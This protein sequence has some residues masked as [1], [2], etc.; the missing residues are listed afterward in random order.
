[1][2]LNMWQK[3]IFPLVVVLTI[4]VVVLTSVRLLITPAFPQIEYRM[5]GFPEDR[6]GFTQADRLILS[7]SAINYLFNHQDP[8]WLNL[9]DQDEFL[10]ETPLYNDREL[11]HMEDVK[12]LVS[13]GLTLWRTAL[14]LF[15]IIMLWAWRAN[16]LPQW[17]QMVSWGGIITIFLMLFLGIGIAFGFESLFTEFH[18]LFFEGDTWLFYT[19]DTLIRLFPIRFWRDGFIAGALLILIGALLTWRLPKF[20]K[21]N[22]EKSTKK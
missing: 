5:P 9:V 7:V 21:V 6:F 17:L 15:V 18:H 20:V 8:E 12:L 3:V 1:M 16:W 2:K 22:G 13:Q 19:S 11:S 10:D 4:L 14:T